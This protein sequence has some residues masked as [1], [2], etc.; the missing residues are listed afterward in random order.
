MD[1]QIDQ[2]LN[3]FD[4]VAKQQSAIKLIKNT[5]GVNW[6]IKVVEGT[7]PVDM[8]MLRKLAVDQHKMLEEEV[9]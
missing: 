9:E 1:N 3:E 4:S 5:K 7:L 2:P 8:D 6:E